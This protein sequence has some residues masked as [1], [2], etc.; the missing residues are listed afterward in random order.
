[1]AKAT[2][3]AAHRTAQN[4]RRV[5]ISLGA[6]TA[7][8]EAR[9]AEAKETLASRFTDIVFSRPYTTPCLRGEGDDYLNL[10]AYFTSDLDAATL[11]DYFKS[12]EAAAG[13]I[14][15][16][17]TRNIV[18]L[19][20]DLVVD[21]NSVLR[22]NDFDRKYFRKGYFELRNPK[23]IDIEEY[24]YP[25][26]D[27]RIALHP[28]KER[29]A[30]R[31][32]VIDGTKTAADTVFNQI[33]NH[34]PSDS[35]LIYNNTRV[36][37]A[38]LIFTKETGSRIEIFCLDPELPADYQLNLSSTHPVRWK[39]L[40]GNSKRWKSGRLTARLDIDG[41]P[42]TL[43][44][45][46]IE[47]SDENSIVEFSWDDTTKS[48]S[49]VL[50]AF[51]NLPI[52]PYLNRDTEESD[53]TEYQ[54]VY[55]KIEGS[56]AAPTAGLHFTDRLLDRLEA[57]G[58]EQR[59]VTLHVG[60][61]TFR[62]VKSATVGEHDMH[63][64]L[65]DVSYE[66]IDELART[67]RPVTAV[68]TT[69]VRTLESLYHIGCKIAANDWNGTLDQWY[70]YATEHPCLS[71]SEA[72]AAILKYLDDRGQRRLIASTRIIIAPSYRFR[73]V[74]NLITNF[75]QPGSTLLLLIAAIVDE[76]WRLIYDYAL[77]HDY[78]FLS[79]GDACLFKGLF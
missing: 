15:S 58:I 28:L 29:D 54:T 68:G 76:N 75:H 27:D 18:P 6:N 34:L 53:K 31:L 17:E 64:E 66:L 16:F 73:I 57:L 69:T 22:P 71:V 33:E 39:C 67:E 19:D 56:V 35:L 42:V 46:R 61:G 21:D 40:V 45:E 59:N 7:D 63:P 13:R 52:P 74:K 24:N 23:N 49:E 36:I 1:M 5:Y 48:F 78:R 25:L 2:D 32:L 44:A 77:E 41:K 47:K 11:V 70:P 30:C 10:V 55:G 4:L 26:P 14:N 60:A 8:K 62:P 3:I 12:F 38:R 37:N 72:L 9:V 43:T 20:I 50:L 65:I 79:Y 51:G